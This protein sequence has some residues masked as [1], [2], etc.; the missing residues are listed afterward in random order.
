MLENYF[1]SDEWNQ[2]EKDNLIK[3]TV[4][5]MERAD[6]PDNIIKPHSL[7][8]G[9]TGECIGY[10]YCKP[11]HDLISLRELFQP[12]NMKNYHINQ[13]VLFK[14][15][16]H[17]LDILEILSEKDIFPGFID[18]SYL[19]VP[20]NHPEKMLFIFHPEFFQAGA[21]PPSYLWYASDIR[22]YEEEFELF[23]KEKQGTADAKLIYKILTACSKGNVKIPPNQ[24]N[25]KL[26]WDYWNM[27]P[28]EWKD[29]FKEFP[30]RG[31]THEEMRR[32]IHNQIGKEVKSDTSDCE[33]LK[34]K[35]KAYA[36]I[37]ILRQA[38]KSVHDISRELYLLQEKLE[39]H[40]SLEFEQGF[41]LG[42]RHPYTRDFR[43]YSKEYRSQL[44]HVI[45]DYSFGE[46]IL[47]A[48]EMMEA[49]LRKEERPSFLFILLDG[50]IINDK[51]FN[52]ALKR[53]ERLK[54]NWY[55]KVIL[56]PVEEFRGE[57]YHLLKDLC[58]KGNK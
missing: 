31:I 44:G 32:L 23:D 20:V 52:I 50:E 47:I 49:A 14:I 7:I 10:S 28:R 15:A 22:L 37:T 3:K 24:Q 42:N 55:T 38:E 17:V 18:L 30:N 4:Y 5:Y 25:Q 41:V 53:V 6:L 26:S 16:E 58:M 46:T 51:I 13:T 8:Y 29:Y 48:V 43:Q 54:E 35:N 57:G 21:I 36:L 27:L 11:I 1:Y 9:E 39:M 56:V 19:Y 45:S 34:K 33:K 40:P 2:E 12:D